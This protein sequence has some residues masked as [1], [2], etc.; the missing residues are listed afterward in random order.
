MRQI[1]P[2]FVLLII[3]T[4]SLDRSS[5]Q[6]I[7]PIKCMCVPFMGKGLS[8]PVW[9]NPRRPSREEG[10]NQLDGWNDIQHICIHTWFVLIHSRVTGL[11]F[12]RLCSHLNVCYMLSFL[13]DK[14][15]LN[16][17]IKAKKVINISLKFCMSQLSHR[18]LVSE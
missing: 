2:K 10:I 8:P 11:Q 13:V 6:N 5:Y 4:H 16:H 12:Q 14:L 1:T 3:S 18:Q 17:S 9:V 7:K 15:Q